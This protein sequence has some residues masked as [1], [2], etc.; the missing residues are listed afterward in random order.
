MSVTSKTDIFAI[1]PA[2]QLHPTLKTAVPVLNCIYL[3]SNSRN[4]KDFASPSQLWQQAGASART[5]VM[6]VQPVPP[7]THFQMLPLLLSL[8]ADLASPPH[9]LLE[10]KNVAQQVVEHVLEDI[11]LFSYSA[12]HLV[13]SRFFYRH[14]VPPAL[15]NLD[16]LLQL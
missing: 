11:S 14:D 6:C 13:S 4:L 10:E 12:I 1:Y 2:C 3:L 5:C 7:C 8:H 16:F 9:P 15:P